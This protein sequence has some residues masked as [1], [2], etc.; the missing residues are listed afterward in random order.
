MTDQPAWPTLASLYIEPLS[1]GGPALAGATGFVVR[2]TDGTD[3]LLTARHVLTG[4][5]DET[6]EIMHES[7]ATPER[8]RI[9]H[10]QSSWHVIHDVVTQELRDDDD[11]PLFF[12]DPSIFVEESADV[13]A[14][15]L[16]RPIERGLVRS[17]DISPLV[18][19]R[20]AVTATVWIVGYP[21]GIRRSGHELAVWS[22]GSVAT[23]PVANWHGDRFLVDSRT[24]PGQ[25][26]SPVI[27]YVP[28]HSSYSPDGQIRHDHPASWTLLG[29]YSGRLYSGNNE[30]SDLGSVWNLSKIREVIGCVT[31]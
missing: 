16:S 25:S 20:P 8:I 23:D 10:Y 9:W 31:S 4:R 6:K 13:A 1:P 2:R 24:R 11:N 29:L 22:R 5:H 15:P 19:R 26:G 7:G 30:S 3:F 17:Y 27:S 14:L 12:E 21:V 28:A 18:D